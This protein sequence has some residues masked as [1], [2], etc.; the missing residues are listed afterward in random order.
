MTIDTYQRAITRLTTDI[1]KLY[2]E[3]GDEQKKEAS[4]MSDILRVRNSIGK[5]ISPSMH[6][7]KLRQI[8]T[9]EKAIADSKKK[10]GELT[11][12]LADKQKQLGREQ[13]KLNKEQLAEQKRL[14]AMQKKA[15]DNQKAMINKMQ[16]RTSQNNVDNEDFGTMQIKEYD[17]FISHAS[18]DKGEIAE[19]LALALIERGV[20]VW[21]DKFSLSVGDSLRK[22]ID[23]GLANSKY[24]IV[25]L[26]PVYFKKFWTEKELN[27]LFAK[28]ANSEEKTILPIWHNISKDTVAS[29][30]PMLADIL[31]LKT[32]DFTINEIADQLCKLIH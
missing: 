30:S 2:K 15:L 28:W 13:E 11:S 18:E 4:K 24:G 8:A 17:F 3:I 16:V 20:N 19:P 5:N 27:G 7:S 22:S 6:A 29:F 32:A 10:Q 14:Q 23:L 9:F 21:Y 31:A 1:S 25:I 26:T 12:K